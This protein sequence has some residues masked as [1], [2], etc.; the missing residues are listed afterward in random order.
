MERA[1]SMIREDMDGATLVV[2]A[3]PLILLILPSSTRSTGFNSFTIG[4]VKITS[5]PP[6]GGAPL[7]LI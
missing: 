7:F 4:Q 1:A 2:Y 6:F 3:M 5:P